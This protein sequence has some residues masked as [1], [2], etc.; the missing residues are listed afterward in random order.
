MSDHPHYDYEL[1]ARLSRRGLPVPAI[2][3]RV[4]CSRRTVYRVIKGHKDNSPEARARRLE[5]QREHEGNI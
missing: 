3:E 1:I 4:G 5:W 2:A